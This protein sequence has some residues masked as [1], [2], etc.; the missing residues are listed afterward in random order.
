VLNAA[1]ERSAPPPG[2]SDG[3]ITAVSATAAVAAGETSADPSLLP[4]TSL[5]D[6]AD[7]SVVGATPTRLAAAP[8]ASPLV[9][10]LHSSSL[11]VGEDSA[12]D[13]GNPDRLFCG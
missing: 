13:L 7:A 10:P 9:V 3:T 11:A 8:P 2:G 4:C 6:T 5:S 12:W 1:V